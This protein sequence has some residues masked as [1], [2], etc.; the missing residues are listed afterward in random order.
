MA[1]NKITDSTIN[2]G[3]PPAEQ[4]HLVEMFSQQIAVSSE[5]RAKA[6]ARAS[7]LATQLGFTQG[8]VIS[9]FRIVGEQDVPPEQIGIKLGEIA[10]KHQALMERWSVL[11]TADPA[12][13]ALAAQAK[14]AIETGQYDEADTALSRA[15]DQE[16]AAARQAEKLARDAQEAAERRWLRVAEADGKRGD[17]AMTRLRYA[18]AAHHF[19]DAAGSVPAA[20]QSERRRYLVQEA[21]ALYRQGDERGDNRAA[22]L[23]IDRWRAIV[24]AT[25]RAV[26]PL[27]WTR[28]QTALGEAL[29]QLGQREP[30]TG[31]LEEAV[32]AFRLALQEGKREREPLDWATAQMDL[33]SAL[34]ML[35]TRETG[36]A[37]L[38][39]AVAAFR[40]ALQEL[41]RER[42]PL[43]WAVTQMNL[44]TALVELGERE[45]GT[46]RLEEAV[47]AYRLALEELDARAGAA[48]MGDDADGPWQRA[49]EAGRARSR[50]GASGGGSGGLPA[51]A[52]GDGR[53]SGC[54]STGRLTQMNLGTSLRALGEREAGTER[55]E[56]AVAAYRLALEETTRERVPLHWALT[57]MN[58]GTALATLGER[59]TRDGASEEAVAAFRQALQER[60]R[61]RV[62]LDWARTQMNLGITLSRLASVRRGRPSGGSGGG[63]PRW[64]SRK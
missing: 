49:F 29:W 30:G 3:L 32:E 8:A 34:L 45:A 48:P 4:L 2:I 9:F 18:D 14:A 53:A 19:A 22:A 20:R 41:T 51:G 38:E 57:Q 6:E 63:L 39:E 64:H 31:R 59:E 40:L 54:R 7:E 62:P 35:G 56:E 42:A 13:A 52:G 46:G 58:L 17:L 61:E 55:L 28:A 47:A 11:D 27:D 1:A 43:A 12:T 10:A 44:G 60:T 33:G 16:A 50:D 23:A 37:R 25:D 5:A 15:S 21:S 36:T 24:G 26:A